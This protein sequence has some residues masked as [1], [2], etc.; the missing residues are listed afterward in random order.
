LDQTRTVQPIHPD[1]NVPVQ[2][3]D[4]RH[5]RLIR[6]EGKRFDDHQARSENYGAHLGKAVEFVRIDGERYRV[7]GAER[8]LRRCLLI[9]PS[10]TA[11]NSDGV[12]E[13][14]IVMC[15]WSWRCLPR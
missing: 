7:R 4:S 3:A 9:P 1:L 12:Y 6:S 11:T 5:R 10:D 8:R 15:R 13:L 14:D 2:R